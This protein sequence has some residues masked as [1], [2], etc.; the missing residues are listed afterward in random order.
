MPHFM[1]KVVFRIFAITILLFSL[2]DNSLGRAGGGGGGGH[3]GGGGGGSYYGGGRYGRGVKWEKGDNERLI[4]ILIVIAIIITFSIIGYK[5]IIKYK[6]LRVNRI[7]DKSANEDA[8]WNKEK[9]EKFV[10]DSYI[11]MQTAWMKQ[12]MNH[13]QDIITSELYDIYQRM[14]DNQNRVGIY[15]HID[16]VRIEKVEFVGVEDY[17]DDNYDR[18]T[19]YISGHMVDLIVRIGINEIKTDKL[20]YFEDLY[21]FVR[22]E[23]SWLLS[24]ITNNVD[25]WTVSELEIKKEKNEA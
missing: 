20:T 7:L 1:R 16:E 10:R 9:L 25:I 15:N 22:F 2:L 4:V 6:A 17:I 11:K 5:W 19:A 18:F 14:L 24:G 21:H 23:N 3:S 8:I 12:D 13:V